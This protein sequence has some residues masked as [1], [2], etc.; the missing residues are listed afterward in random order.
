MTT[1]EIE[2]VVRALITVVDNLETGSARQS[3]QE[4]FT[5]VRAHA[6]ATRASAKVRPPGQREAGAW[7]VSDQIRTGAHEETHYASQ[8]HRR[9]LPI[10]PVRSQR[11]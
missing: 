6:S 9:W 5:Q 7:S 1:E 10:L 8:R 3:M 4:A 2:D 11:V